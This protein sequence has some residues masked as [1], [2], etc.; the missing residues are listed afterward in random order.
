LENGGDAEL[1][2]D[3]DSVSMPV[4]VLA[5]EHLRDISGTTLFFRPEEVVASRR[6]EVVKKWK[7]RLRKGS[8]RYP[9]S[10]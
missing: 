3:L 2:A 8:I 1:V 6:D 10:E 7:V 9:E 5:S 4:R